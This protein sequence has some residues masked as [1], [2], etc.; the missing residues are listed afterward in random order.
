MKGESLFL[1]YGAPGGMNTHRGSP[2]F[3]YCSSNSNA[4]G[5]SSILLL[6]PFLRGK[7]PFGVFFFFF[8]SSFFFSFFFFFLCLLVPF[9][10]VSS[11]CPSDA[12]IDCLI[13]HRGVVSELDWTVP[14]ELPCVV[15]LNF[16]DTAGS[17]IYIVL[18][19]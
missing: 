5:N 3:F 8:F 14:V 10:F 12:A 17:H 13:L 7:L 2:L 11:F 6:R 9:T 1:R 18:E 15:P 16:M 19:E 4:Y